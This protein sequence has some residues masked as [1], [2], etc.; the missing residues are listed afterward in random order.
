MLAG[1]LWNA[2]KE[3]GALGEQILAGDHGATAR[4]VVRPLVALNKKGREKR[5]LE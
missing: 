4:S 1:V 2:P 3:L 5:K